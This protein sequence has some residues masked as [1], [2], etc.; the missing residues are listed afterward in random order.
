MKKYPYD[1]F[2][3]TESIFSEDENAE[4]L[5]DSPDPWELYSFTSGRFVENEEHELAQRYRSFDILELA[6]RAARAVQAD[7]CLRIEKF[8]DGF[9]NRILLLTL[10]N[11]KEVVAKIPNPNAGRPH[12]TTASE[13]ATM[14]FARE[15][16]GTNLPRVLDWSSRAQDTTVGAEFILMERL[17]GAHLEDVW[18]EMKIEDRNEVVKAVAAYQK[19]WASVTFEQYG[20]LYFAEDYKGQNAPALVYTDENGRRVE[21]PRFVIGPSTS[22]EM[23]DYGRGDIEFDR[24]PWKSLEEYH[25]AIGHRELACVQHLPNLHPSSLT[26]RGPGLYQPTREEKVAAI[27]TYLK[28]LKYALPADRSLGSSHL[29]HNSLHAGNI[30]V[31]LENPGRIVG[32]IDWQSTELS[33]LYFRSHQPPFMRHAGPQLH[34]LDHPVWPP[35]YDDL[36]GDAKRA[37]DALFWDQTLCSMYRALVHHRI[38][39]LFKC[40]EFQESTSYS[41][42]NTALR[43]SV[44]G[45]ALHLAVVCELEKEWETLPGTQGIPFP[46]SLT[47]TDREKIHEDAM[48][49]AVGIEAMHRIKSRLGEHFPEKGFVLHDEHEMVIDALSQATKEV[50][51]EVEEIREELDLLDAQD[52]QTDSLRR[53][54]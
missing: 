50:L 22:R 31:D 45:E 15:V 54:G 43:L 5:I 26:L 6:R 11:G 23:F 37:A 3:R 1:P 25:A 24:G 18:P 49:V 38:P 41:L 36:K 44:D 2:R 13:V 14:K 19:S 12:F 40:F 39:K 27:E 8:P 33:P 48:S 42:L 21:D 35:G 34:G 17:D 32:I 28:L 4:I 10:G 9:Y 30:L 20:S 52:C 47:A 53:S 51:S 16:L 7:S 46:L 29:W